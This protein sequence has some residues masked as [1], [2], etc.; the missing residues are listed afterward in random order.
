MNQVTVPCPKCDTF[1]SHV[2]TTRRNSEGVL[3]RRR[4]CKECDYRW[5][6]MQYPEVSM[7]IK[8]KKK[9]R[10]PRKYADHTAPD[11]YDPVTGLEIKG[12][13]FVYPE[14][15]LAPSQETLFGS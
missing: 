3:I 5:Y 1:S 9:G 2:V 11:G 8:P 13:A 6:T 15:S 7:T 10:K 14:E 4:H 12:G